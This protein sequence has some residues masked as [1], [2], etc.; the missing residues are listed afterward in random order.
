MAAILS[1]EEVFGPGKGSGLLSDADVF[2]KGAPESAD[3]QRGRAMGS[4][5]QGFFSAM[6]GPTLSFVDEIAGAGGAI[7]GGIANAFG[8]DDGTSFA[9]RYRRTRD[10]V[11]GAQAQFAEDRPILNTATQLAA[12][13][14]LIAV[15]GPAPAALGVARAAPVGVLATTGQAAKTAAAFGGAQGLGDSTAEDVGGMLSDA[16]TGAG[17]SVLFA[18]TANA[19][20]N[21]VGKA[22][23]TVRRAVSK[24]AAQDYARLKVAEAIA[25]EGRGNP[26]GIEDLQAGLRQMGDEARVVDAGGDAMRGLLD[27]VA[28]MPGRAKGMVEGAI[29]ERQA[30][31]GARLVSAADDALGTGGRGFT[32]ELEALAAAKSAESAPLYAAVRD[33]PVALTD[34]VKMLLAKVPNAAWKDARTIIKAETGQDLSVADLLGRDAIP[35]GVLDSVKRGLYTAGEALKREGKG[36]VALPVDDVRRQLIDKL[37]ALSP[38]DALG[39]SI[40][41][42]ARETFGGFARLEELV[43]GG[44]KAFTDDTLD[45]AALTKGLSGTELDA[46]RIGALQALRQKIGTEGGQTSLLKY[47][48]EPATQSRLRAIFGDGQ[49]GLSKFTQAL[50]REGKLK[51]LESVGRGSQTASRMAAM[52][53]LATNPAGQVARGQIIQPLIDGASRLYARMQTPEATR[54]EIAR[55]LL[56]RASDDGGKQLNSLRAALDRVNDARIKRAAA[57]GSFAGVAGF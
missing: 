34:D 12:G 11:R 48:K 45:L 42:N 46:F 44:R 32:D 19:G 4:G 57:A 52:D 43:Q 55:I 37:D 40:Y 28:T 8:K 33:M 9:E 3:F 49:E 15:G 5:V 29:R 25:R 36:G 21:A 20:M 54:D 6:Q 7:F 51:G 50:E 38:K 1:D 23:G 30:G 53:D 13:S 41:K 22:A 26:L 31:R 18:G 2:G 14:P 17:K 35:L 24:S 10:A 27:T 56:A 16:A 39:A 47:W